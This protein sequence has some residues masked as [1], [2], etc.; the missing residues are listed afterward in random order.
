M[1]FVDKIK[2]YL[3]KYIVRKISEISAPEAQSNIEQGK[4]SI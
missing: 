3:W 4:E 2:K 1:I